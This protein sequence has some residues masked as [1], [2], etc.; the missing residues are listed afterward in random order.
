VADGFRRGDTRRDF[1]DR[2]REFLDT[3]N[4]QRSTLHHAMKVDFATLLG[5]AD[6]LSAIPRPDEGGYNGMVAELRAAFAEYQQDGM[7]V[8]PL[9]CELHLV[10]LRVG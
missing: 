10:R 2:L 8:T 3:S 7:L 5:Y 4:W 6:S 9:A 1:N